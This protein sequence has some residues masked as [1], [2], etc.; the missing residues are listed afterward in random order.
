LRAPPDRRRPGTSR[1][2]AGWDAYAQ[3]YDWEN[4][5][6]FGR[7]DLAFWRRI[8]RREDPPV[9]ELGC[10]TGRL[11]LPLARVV[12]PIT[13]ID[14]S[15]SMLARARAKIARR[16]AVAAPGLIRGDITSLPFASRAF[17][18]VIAP[19]GMLQSL[20]DD[21]H[22]GRTIREVARVLRPGG[23]AGIDLVP[24]LPAWSEYRR[25]VR[26]RGRTGG[27]R[28]TLVE[29]VHQDRRRG[30]TV[31][32]EEFLVRRGRAE[33]RR[34]FS[35]VFRTLEVAALLNRLAAAGLSAETVL[36]DYRGGPLSERSDAWLILARKK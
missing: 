2:W 13:G 6:T 9:L 23:L 28:I 4:A 15:A 20:L 27:A 11:L 22:L 26:L 3:F 5:Q 17:G 14:R 8:A 18:L 35:L 31:F 19:Y 7:R 1:G 24:D 16:K 21:L 12:R 32:D 10:G 36:G 30:L 29:T 34:T 33:E 25:R